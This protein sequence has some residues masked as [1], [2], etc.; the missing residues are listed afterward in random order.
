MSVYLP[1]PEDFSEA[2]KGRYLG[3]YIFY[4]VDANGNRS[5]GSGKI[6]LGEM[7][8]LR[9][10][11]DGGTIEGDFA[12]LMSDDEAAFFLDLYAITQVFL[13]SRPQKQWRH[14]IQ[15][16]RFNLDAK[17]PYLG[18]MLI[19][20]ASD[21]KTTK[22]QFFFRRQ[23]IEQIVGF[24]ADPH[25]SFADMFWEVQIQLDLMFANVPT[26]KARQIERRIGFYKMI[27]LPKEGRV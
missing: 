13:K 20:P 27:F 12:H 17:E 5:D 2:P 26:A 16:L 21:R 23:G 25:D 9:S 11:T 8:S 10:P 4:R 18:W 1:T 24:I 22:L 15:S 19:P 7:L 6:V 14:I 3:E